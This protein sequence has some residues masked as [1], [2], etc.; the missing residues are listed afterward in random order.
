MAVQ[1]K[2]YGSIGVYWGPASTFNLSQLATMN[3]F[4]NQRAELEAILMALRQ[5]EKREM[6][7]LIL[8]TDSA[9]AVDCLTVHRNSWQ[10]GVTADGKDPVL[11]DAKGN[12]PRNDDLF[13]AIFASLRSINCPKVFFQ[14]VKRAYNAEADHLAAAVFQNKL[15]NPAPVISSVKT[16]AQKERERMSTIQEWRP[17]PRFD[18]NITNNQSYSWEF[19]DEGVIVVLSDTDSEPAQSPRRWQ[20]Y[21]QRDDV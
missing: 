6:P 7:R 17:T 11:T 3:P 4:T 8:I 16:R 10:E 14:H 2:K 9:Y 19:D 12:T 15:I 1:G 20:Q 21:H 5:A 18:G 13:I